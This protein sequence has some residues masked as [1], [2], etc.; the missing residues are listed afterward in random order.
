MPERDRLRIAIY[1]QQVE[2]QHAAHDE[3]E[4]DPRKDIGRHSDH[5][6]LERAEG[7]PDCRAWQPAAA[8]HDEW[9]GWRR[10]PG[11][12]LPFSAIRSRPKLR[13]SSDRTYGAA[14]VSTVT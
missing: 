10:G 3:G 12:V 13:P 5:L 8:G 7:L 1:D 2:G 9:P 11:G 6:R 14:I 4:R